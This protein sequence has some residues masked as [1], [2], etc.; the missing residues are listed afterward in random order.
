MSVLGSCELIRTTTNPSQDQL[1]FLDT[2]DSC[3]NILLSLIQNVLQFS[4]LEQGKERI[5][6][7]E[8]KDFDLRRFINSTVDIMLMYTSDRAV[9]IKTEI[10]QNL[11]EFVRGDRIKLQQCLINL[12]SNAVKVSQTNGVVTLS[13]YRD[14]DKM[15]T[16]FRISDNGPGISQ[17]KQH[18]LFQPFGQIHQISERTY[19]S[20]GLGLVICKKLVTEMGGEISFETDISEANHGSSFFFRLYLEPML[21]E[22]SEILIERSC[23]THSRKIVLAEDNAVIRS[24]LARLLRQ[25]GYSVHETQSGKELVDYFETLDGVREPWPIVVTDLHMPMMDGLQAA[26]KLKQK[27]RK[28]GIILLTA[29]AF[30]EQ[31]ELSYVDIMLT[32]PVKGPILTSSIQDLILKLD[33]VS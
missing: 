21:K 32:K 24:V 29:D 33:L 18:L 28:I 11:P 17:E 20:T 30:L 8:L 4:R 5:E 7:K 9:S 27:N 15:S 6:N 23:V 22:D 3:S 25:G 26:E 14:I 19:P 2:I 31:S 1:K 13:I 16:V 10:D 12:L